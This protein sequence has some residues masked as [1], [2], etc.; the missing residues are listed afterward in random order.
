MLAPASREVR[1]TLLA[2][3]VLLAAGA[4]AFAPTLGGLA[5]RWGHDSRYSH[6]YLVP[7]FSLFL[8]WRQREALCGP[9]MEPSWWGLGV[10]AAGLALSAAGTGV[11]LDW[12]NALALPACLAGGVVLLRGWRGLGVAWPALAFLLF[13]V[14]LPYQLEVALAHPLQRVATKL[15]TLAIQTL[16]FVAV[17]EGNTIRMGAVRIGVVEACSGLSMLMIFFALCTAAALLLRRPLVERLLVVASAV[18]IALLANVLRIV[19]TAVLHKLAGHELADLVFHDLAGWLMMPLALGMLWLGY[20]LFSWVFPLRA[21]AE[22]TPG[23]P[24]AI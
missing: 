22:Q 18:P 7:L 5:E 4:W 23:L 1:R 3:G 19:V 10:L 8:L 16:G 15:S 17:A 13:M 14:P 20:R 11:Y 12:F 9:G 21:P 6:G 2:A 24:F